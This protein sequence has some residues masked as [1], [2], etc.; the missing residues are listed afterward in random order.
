MVIH[1]VRVVAFTCLRLY[2]KDHD[3]RAFAREVISIA[4]PMR[5]SGA[6][7]LWL[8]A[9]AHGLLSTTAPPTLLDTLFDAS[10]SSLF[11]TAGLWATDAPFLRDGHRKPQR[12]LAFSHG[13]LGRHTI[14]STL[15]VG[16]LTCRDRV[17]LELAYRALDITVSSKQRGTQ[18]RSSSS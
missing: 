16:W 8:A 15:L 6:N 2:G 11:T 12:S 4:F 10:L 3:V 14:G 1:V 13:A 9:R 18:L 17:R 7:A 5:A